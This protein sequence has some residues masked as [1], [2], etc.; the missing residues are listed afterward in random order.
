LKV[1]FKRFTRKRN[2]EFEKGDF[3]T[4][5]KYWGL[6]KQGYKVALQ[7]RFDFVMGLIRIPLSL[8]VFYFLWKAVFSYS[9][10]DVINGYS[11]AEMVSYYVL[12]MIVGTF[13]WF[14]FDGWI[15]WG[16]KTGNIVGDFM[17]PM[18]LIYIYLFAQFGIKSLGLVIHLLPT[19]FIGVFFFGLQFTGVLNLVLFGF[20]LVCAVFLSFFFTMFVGMLSFWFV[21][22]KGLIKVKNVMLAFFSGTIIPLSFFPEII[23]KV[24]DF[25]PFQYMRYVPINFYLGLYDF[26]QIVFYLV[27]MVLWVLIM[28]VVVYFETKFAL[29]KATGVGI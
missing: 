19:L 21:E 8:V 6:I 27:M 4:M 11:F 22:I 7:Y 18:N 29:K 23:Q 10:E 1:L 15:R 24:F 28:W 26:S 17:M 13:T 5:R 20:A 14:D 2:D 16:V 12:S 3:Q 25:L 9:A